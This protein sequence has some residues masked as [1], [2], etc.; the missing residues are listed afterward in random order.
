M[1]E[2]FLRDREIDFEFFVFAN[3]EIKYTTKNNYDVD[4]QAK[5]LYRTLSN[6]TII[7]DGMPISINNVTEEQIEYIRNVIA[8]FK[9]KIQ[10]YKK[11]Y[12]PY[13]IKYTFGND[14]IEIIANTTTIEIPDPKHFKEWAHI[15]CFEYLQHFLDEYEKQNSKGIKV[16]K[17]IT[18]FFTK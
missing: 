16:K 17:K 18:S 12:I 1:L 2:I 4:D 8:T 10:T 3:N 7:L 15:K 14:V 5:A 6:G 13:F 11:N 9:E